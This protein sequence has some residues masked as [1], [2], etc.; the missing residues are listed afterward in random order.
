MLGDGRALAKVDQYFN[1][2]WA[3]YETVEVRESA[4]QRSLVRVFDRW[5]S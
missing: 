5:Q 1:G 4:G 2:K 3:T